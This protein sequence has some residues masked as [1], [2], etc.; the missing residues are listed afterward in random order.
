VGVCGSGGAVLAE[1]FGEGVTKSLVV[2]LQ[3][4]DALG[5]D[6][7]ATQEGGV[8]AALAVWDGTGRGGTPSVAQLFD[9]GAQVGLVVEQ[10]PGDALL[11]EQSREFP[12]FNDYLERYGLRP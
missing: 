9:L 6:L 2:G 4:T 3:L 5:G 11:T 12:Q 7:D 8:R 1:G 10:G